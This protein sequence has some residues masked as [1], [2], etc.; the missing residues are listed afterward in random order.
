MTAATSGQAVLVSGLTVLIAMAGMLLAGNPVF[1]SIGIGTMIMISV[2][3]VGSLTILPALLSKLEDRV[4]R[5]R[6][7]LVSRV[8]RPG[9]DS[10][11]W[12]AIITAVTR[13]PLVSL[14]AASAALLAL[15][16]PALGMHTR[17]LS[18]TDLPTS[19]PVIKAYNDIQKAFPGAQT[20]AEVIVK[21][22][23]VRAPQ[24][25]IVKTV[26]SLGRIPA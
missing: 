3:I 17:L 26:I 10:R 5:G 21:A 12:G 22:P 1:T 6:I 25:V 7:P 24:V 23:N 16:T 15:A 2:A 14:V 13:R 4:D 9:G 19:L 18:Y 11:F 20:P 8:Q